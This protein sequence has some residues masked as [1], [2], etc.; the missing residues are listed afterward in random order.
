MNNFFDILFNYT[1]Y[2]ATFLT[3]VVG[4]ISIKTYWD[5]KI[6]KL[7]D[8]INDLENKYNELHNHYKKI[9]DCDN[10]SQSITR[11]LERGENDIIIIRE[12][13]TKL[14]GEISYLKKR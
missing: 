13:I 2:I 11:R 3:I 8:K 9:H 6:E 1:N 10:I 14:E 7:N 4:I 5:K 12:R